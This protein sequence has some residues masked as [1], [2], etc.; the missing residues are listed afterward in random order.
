MVA[1]YDEKDADNE[2]GEAD[3]EN[4]CFDNFSFG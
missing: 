4:T 1:D 3:D 2:E